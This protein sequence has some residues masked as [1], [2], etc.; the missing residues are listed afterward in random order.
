[1]A[2]VQSLVGELRSC[3]PHGVTKTK[4]QKNGFLETESAFHLYW[5]QKDLG[6]EA[7]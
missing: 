4:K 2:Q 1:M 7:V 6:Y 5:A 3:K